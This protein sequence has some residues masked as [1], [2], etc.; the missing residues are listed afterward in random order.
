MANILPTLLPPPTLVRTVVST[1]G[2][3]APPT[4]GQLWPRISQK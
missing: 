1:V 3:S 2:T 4:T